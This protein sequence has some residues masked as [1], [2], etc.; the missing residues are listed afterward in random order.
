METNERARV[1]RKRS[2]ASRAAILEAALDLVRTSGYDDVT[3]DAIAAH[4]NVGKQTIYRWWGSV[5]EVMLE[6]L[7][8]S[9]RTIPTPETGSLEGDVEALFRGSFKL[10]KGT[11]GT[12]P[13]LKGL[14][15]DAQLDEAFLPFFRSFVEERRATLRGVL[16]RHSRAGDL[17][18]DAV[19]DM[20]YGALWYRLLLGHGKL[21]AEFASLLGKNAARSLRAKGNDR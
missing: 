10:L 13:V 9:A 18:I 1:G 17:E 7:R 15:A 2:E 4:A 14:M 11:T 8:T 3:A 20:L 16:R 19:V 6:A 5:K 21:D 12:G